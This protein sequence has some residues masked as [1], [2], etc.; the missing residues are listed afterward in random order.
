M[1]ARFPRL[2]TAAI[3][4]LIALPLGGCGGGESAEP[5]PGA[6]DAKP[7]KPTGGVDLSDKDFVDLSSSATVAVQARDNSFV[8]PYIEV[9]A[10]STIT[11]TNRGRTE[12]NVL[13]VTKGEFPGIEVA[14]F[15]PKDVGTITFDK[16]G[17]YPYYCS[18]HGTPTKGMTGAIRVLK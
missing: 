16:P 11:F 9:Q 2:R 10:G 5:A 1:L 4:L 18:L 13:P 17:D 12:H 14:D 3:V 15:A 7:I 6:G 8:K